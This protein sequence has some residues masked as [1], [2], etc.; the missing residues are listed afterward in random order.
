MNSNGNLHTPNVTSLETVSIVRGV[1]A[2]TFSVGMS[3]V[4]DVQASIVNRVV[5]LEMI[6]VLSAQLAGVFSV[7]MALI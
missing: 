1:P 5:Y 4:R 2:A 7:R 3:A 6:Q